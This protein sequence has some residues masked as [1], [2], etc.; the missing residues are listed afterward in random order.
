MTWT[1]DSPA[2]WSAIG[3]RGEYTVEQRM[4]I[5]MAFA[6]DADSAIC[7]IHGENYCKQACERYDK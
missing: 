4:G 7:A 2:M 5:W 3:V 6:P 1:K